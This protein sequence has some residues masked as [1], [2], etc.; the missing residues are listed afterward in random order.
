MF[1]AFLSPEKRSLENH[2]LV[3]ESLENLLVS[4]RESVFEL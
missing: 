4:N 1:K 3:F 2:V